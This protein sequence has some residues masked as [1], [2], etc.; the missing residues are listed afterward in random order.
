MAFICGKNMKYNN[1][2]NSPKFKVSFYEHVRHFWNVAV[3]NE[4]IAKEMQNNIL[5]K[6]EVLEGLLASENHDAITWLGHACVLIKLNNIRILCDP[7]LTQKIYPIPFY[8]NRNMIPPVINLSDLPKIDIL[9]ITH[10]HFDHLNLP[11]IKLMSNKEST[12]VVV[13]L[14]LGR[15]FEKLGYKKII[16]LN[17][18]QEVNLAQINIR[19][20]PAI[21]TSR[22][23]LLDKDTTL[24][25]SYLIDSSYKKI[26]LSCDSAYGQF[27]E[28]LGGK[29]NNIDLA[30]LSIGAYGPQSYNKSLHATPE[31]A[32]KI[33]LHMQ[34]KNILGIHWGTLKITEEP[35]CEPAERFQIAGIE[36]G[37]RKENILLLKIGETRELSNL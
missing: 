20:I 25:S 14:G 13:P 27:Y 23:N 30:V 17:W 34:A 26:Y 9:L 28:D 12:S 16:E 36:A 2:K 3:D 29:I 19:A 37:Y 31:D 18:W 35:I 15:Y 33:A 1:P 21:H 10:N 32:L 24:W 4:D 8:T 5:K 6:Q 7:L 11:T 22:R